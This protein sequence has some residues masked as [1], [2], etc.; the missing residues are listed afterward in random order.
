MIGS[1]NK[2]L[3][4]FQF[5]DEKECQND[6]QLAHYIKDTSYYRHFPV[7]KKQLFDLLLESLHM[8]DQ[9]TSIDE[10]IKAAANQ[11]RI[12]VKRGFL[13]EAKRLIAKS[14]KKAYLYERFYLLLELISVEKSIQANEF[15]TDEELLL[16]LYK[17]ERAVLFKRSRENDY[18]YL[19]SKIYKYHF[20]R[21]S[22]R[23]EGESNQLDLLLE[24]QLLQDS[25]HAITFQSRLDYYQLNALK[26]F[27]SGN[28]AKAAACN[29]RFIDEFERHPQ[30]TRIFA[31]RYLA[32]FNNYL[33]DRFILKDY[34]TLRLGLKRLRSIPAEP[35]FKK[36]PNVDLTIFRLLVQMELNL[37]IALK[38][39][40][41]N[42]SKIP[43]ILLQME[44]FGDR[45]VEHNL[46]TFYYLF[47]YSYFGNNQFEEVIDWTNRI[48]DNTSENVLTEI[49]TAA[50]LINLLA[51]YH[52]GNEELLSYAINNV[53]R[54]QSRRDRLF[55]LEK[56][57]LSALQRSIQQLPER[58]V[59]IFQKLEKELVELKNNPKENAPFNNF[60]YLT[61]VKSQIPLK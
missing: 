34:K 19:F 42:V 51:H 11:S 56:K 38:D 23:S 37:G 4:L 13:K 7:A 60:D 20:K 14:K 18:W 3:E 9:A 22:L 55:T 24:D 5:I 46:V 16:S 17:E 45:L 31:E 44:Q 28:G 10:Q 25:K 59:R 58:R 48:I 40:K 52:S 33:I 35:E 41:T 57:L 21:Q 29:M 43:A 27:L 12:L 50:R 54:Y 39:F 30:M 1:K 26:H 2:Y 8:Y 47:A 53:R 32:T 36:I 6:A 61:W 49:Q 15:Y